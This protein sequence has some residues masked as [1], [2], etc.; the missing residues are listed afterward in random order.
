[1]LK[2]LQVGLGR[3]LRKFSIAVCKST[4]ILRFV[5]KIQNLSIKDSIK[6]FYE[7]LTFVLLHKT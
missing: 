2:L 6:V 5:S 1:M 4:Q 3:I 7:Y